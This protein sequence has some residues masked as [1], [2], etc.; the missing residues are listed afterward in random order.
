MPRARAKKRDGDEVKRT[1]AIP[2]WSRVSPPTSAH[3]EQPRNRRSIGNQSYPPAT[4]PGGWGRYEDPS[5]GRFNARGNVRTPR[6]NIETFRSFSERSH[7]FDGAW[8]AA[9]G[10][11][12][13][14][15]IRRRQRSAQHRV[16]FARSESL[17][18][19]TLGGA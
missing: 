19:A 1:R 12:A 15:S 11:S 18:A 6:R 5:P 10:R 3:Q 14:L 17:A 9:S 8:N 16:D 4:L 2:D 7:N 13:V